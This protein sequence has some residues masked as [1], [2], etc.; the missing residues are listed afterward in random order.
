MRFL[1]TTKL[2]IITV[3]SVDSVEPCA[4][5]KPQNSTSGK[6]QAIT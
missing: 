1:Y 6:L 2:L 5:I 3:C 4:Q